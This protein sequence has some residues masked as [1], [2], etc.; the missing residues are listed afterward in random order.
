MPHKTERFKMRFDP[1]MLTRIDRW[2]RDQP[3]LP[4]RAESIRRLVEQALAST[5]AKGRRSVA[6]TESASAMAGRTIDRLSDTSAPDVEQATRKKRLLH[7]PKEFRKM[8]A[9]S[10]KV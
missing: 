10:R 4:P 5:K 2:R 1:E 3:D 8:R 9:K 6:A 7:G